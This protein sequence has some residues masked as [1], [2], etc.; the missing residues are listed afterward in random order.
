MAKLHDQTY[1]TEHSQRLDNQRFG[2]MYFKIVLFTF[3]S[4]DVNM[5]G[6][7]HTYHAFHEQL[8][9]LLS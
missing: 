4:I 3:E 6:D 9:F 1:T 7:Y 8:Y 2:F 5:C